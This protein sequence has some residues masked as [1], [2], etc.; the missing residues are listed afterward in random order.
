MNQLR[1]SLESFLRQNEWA[2][3]TLYDEICFEAEYDGQNG[4]WKV[5]LLVT[6]YEREGIII[7][8]FPCRVAPRLRVECAELLGRL[9]AEPPPKGVF[10]KKHDGFS[11]DNRYV[12]FR[13]RIFRDKLEGF[14]LWLVSRC[15]FDHLEV[16][17][18]HF[19]EI[20]I[21][22]YGGKSGKDAADRD[23][24]IHS[25]SLFQLN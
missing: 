15:I 21:A 3:R 16:G 4:A 11:L 2:Y 12:T 24:L 8:N 13:S 6:E 18:R 25:Q 5:S 14:P 17:E 19:G 20:M 7:S 1:E 23:P 10:L 9:N 22:A